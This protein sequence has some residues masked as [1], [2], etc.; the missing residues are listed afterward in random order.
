VKEENTTKT[1]IET[2]EKSNDKSQHVRCQHLSNILWEF[3]EMTC[4]AMII[5]LVDTT[6]YF[7]IANCTLSIEDVDII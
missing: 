4:D 3:L 7:I 2:R 6:Y 1:I 5:I